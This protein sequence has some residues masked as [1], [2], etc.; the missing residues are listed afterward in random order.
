MSTQNKKKIGQQ[1]DQINDLSRQR[2]TQQSNFS[3][4]M[5]VQSPSWLKYLL[6]FSFFGVFGLWMTSSGGEQ[7]TNNTSEVVENVTSWTNAPDQ[8]LLNRMGAW[9]SEMGYGNLSNSDLAELRRNGVT[10]TFTSKIRELGYTDVTLDELVSLRQHDVSG[11]FA[12]MMHELGYSDITLDE[13]KRL[14][15]NGVTAY[16][17]SNV[18]DL[19]YDD[20]TIDE[21]I[22][23]QNARMS[24]SDIRRA[25]SELGEDVSIDRLVRYGISNQ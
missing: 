10:A 2:L 4:W 25:Q 13:L 23:L 5:G 15:D 9:M 6:L 1:L 16:Y 7:V 17:T 8:D 24:I 18:H 12:S 3:R 11:T 19:G 20:I 14:R 22:S 21:L